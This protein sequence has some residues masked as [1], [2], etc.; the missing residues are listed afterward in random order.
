MRELFLLVMITIRDKSIYFQ[1]LNIFYRRR[2]FSPQYIFGGI[3]SI[4]NCCNSIMSKLK[5]IYEY[6]TSNFLSRIWEKYSK[7]FIF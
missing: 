7:Y 3:Y 4:A 2:Y 6:T 1:F 5:M